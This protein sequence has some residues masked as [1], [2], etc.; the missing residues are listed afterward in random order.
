MRLLSW[1]PGSAEG[2][3]AAGLRAAAG[4]STL[5]RRGALQGRAVRGDLGIAADECEELDGDP[6]KP[7]SDESAFRM[8][9]DAGETVGLLLKE[10]PLPVRRIRESDLRLVQRV[11]ED[12]SHLVC[13]HRG[14]CVDLVG[15][16]DVPVD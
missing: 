14:E 7:C 12:V 1:G 9:P 6:E 16:R 3:E 13:L 15:G 2:H 8:G 4:E 5:D 10:L 11:L